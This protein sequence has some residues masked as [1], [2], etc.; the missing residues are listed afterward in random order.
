MMMLNNASKDKSYL[1]LLK[2]LMV[3]TKILQ[4][5]LKVI[6]FNVNT[7]KILDQ[8]KLK[9]FLK[10]KNFA[11]HNVTANSIKPEC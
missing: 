9:A 1:N 4:Q 6:N 5:R 10:A 11:S 2:Y 7:K 3:L 8:T